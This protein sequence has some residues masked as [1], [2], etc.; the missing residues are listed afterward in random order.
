MSQKLFGQDTDKLRGYI[1]EKEYDPL[2][3]KLNHELILQNN[4]KNINRY[5][6][7]ELDEVFSDFFNQW[8]KDGM[9]NYGKRR[10]VFIPDTTVF[11][12]IS[13]T[14]T[15]FFTTFKIRSNGLIEVQYY[16]KCHKNTDPDDYM[17]CLDMWH[18]ID[19]RNSYISSNDLMEVILH[20]RTM[21]VSLDIIQKLFPKTYKQYLKFKMLY[22]KSSKQLN[23]IYKMMCYKNPSIFWS[24]K[25][26]IEKLYFGDDIPNIYASFKV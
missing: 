14:M 8:V 19:R 6:A 10:M 1:Y 23:I 24:K 7:N 26:L 17:C 15:R 5:S 25:K 18:R 16:K 2:G 21:V 11:N 20:E 9:P 12:I 22:D 4:Q 3:T 13:P